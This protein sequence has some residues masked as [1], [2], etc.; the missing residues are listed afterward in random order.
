MTTPPLTPFEGRMSYC[1]IK[2]MQM[3]LANPGHVY[4]LPW[5]E[6]V[7][8]EPFGFVYVRDKAHFFAIDGYGYHLAGEHLLRTLNYTYTYTDA[9][10]DTSAL[11]ALENALKSGPV[12]AGMLDMGYLTYIPYHQQLYGSDHA[13]VVLALQ[14]DAVIVHDPEGYVAVPLPL[15]DFLAGWQRDIYTGKPY[16]LWQIGAQG[17]PPTEDEIWERTLARARTNFACTPETFANGMTLLYGPDAMRTLAADLRSWPELAL[18]S[19]P[20]F[21]WRVSAQRCLDSAFFLQARLPQAAAIRWEECL[22]YGQLQ[23]ASA[24]NKRAVLPE[25]LEQLAEYETRFIAALA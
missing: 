10:D 21:N 20:S 19:L 4:S 17:R 8:G 18:G 2:C 5:L 1:L 16:G 7:S 14:P 25:L 23:H 11:A 13:I 15:S 24:V 9:T 3:V 6:C 12:V 22:I